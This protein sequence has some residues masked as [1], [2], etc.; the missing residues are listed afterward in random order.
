MLCHDII[1]TFFNCY[2]DLYYFTIIKALTIVDLNNDK[3][4][5]ELYV[6]S[7]SHKKVRYKKRQKYIRKVE[8]DSK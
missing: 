7:F 2:L 1:K 3:I 8:K 5:I 6:D 4:F